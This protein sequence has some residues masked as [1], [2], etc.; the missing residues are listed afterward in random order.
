MLAET[1]RIEL[2]TLE[3][4]VGCSAGALKESNDEAEE[5]S[6]RQGKG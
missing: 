6:V 1:L 5:V 2:L 4:A 3:K